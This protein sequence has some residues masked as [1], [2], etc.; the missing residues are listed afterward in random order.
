ARYMDL[1]LNASGLGYY[2][3]PARRFGREVDFVTAPEMSP[4]F[5]R[6]LARQIGQVLGHLGGGE[7]FEAGAGSGSLCADLLNA[8]DD[9]DKMPARYLIL[10]PSA[11]LRARQRETLE[12][13]A[14]RQISRVV[15]MDDLPAAGFTG[16]ILANE[17]LDAIPAPRFK[18]SANRVLEAFVCKRGGGFGWL[19]GAPEDDGIIES[20]AEIEAELG[21]PFAD[22]Y[23][24]ELGHARE[25]WLSSAAG[26]LRRGAVLLLDYGYTLSE[27][28]HPQRLDGTLACYYRHRLHADP[29][30]WPGLQDISVHVEFSGL[31]RAATA[32][33]LD[34]AG[35]TSQAEFLI[36]TG[37]LDAGEAP[38]PASLEFVRFANQIKRL[39][40]PGEMG[41]LV[42]VLALTRGT[43]R[44][45]VGFSGRDYRDRL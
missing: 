29:F 4:L 18:K 44:S 30:F 1:A 2:R 45:L 8:L 39:T 12:L 11:A 16:V 42:K 28:Y 27:Y 6:C 20:V 10:E 26:R 22:G 32:A 7:V 33:G 23:T 14:P 38:D 31:C 13:R 5:A 36:A 21:E 9:L 41:E 24:S 35:F 40:L 15:W 3:A 37:V 19:Y 34:V 43:D 17:L 25:A